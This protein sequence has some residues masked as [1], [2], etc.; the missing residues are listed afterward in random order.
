MAAVAAALAD[1][2]RSDHCI[3]AIFK[4]AWQHNYLSELNR[5]IQSIETQHG[6]GAV[7]INRN[8]A[9]ML[10]DEHII[11][12]QNSDGTVLLERAVSVKLN[13]ARYEAINSTLDQY[14]STD[15]CKLIS[16]YDDEIEIC[17]KNR[18]EIIA[19]ME[20]G[21][22][23]AKSALIAAASHQHQIRY[24]NELFKGKPL[25]LNSVDLSNLDLSGIDLTHANIC[26]ANLQNCCLVDASL[27]HASFTASNLNQANLMRANLT[28]TFLACTRLIAANLHAANLRGATLINTCLLCANLE[29]ADLGNSMDLDLT[30][31]NFANFKVGVYG[32]TRL[33]HQSLL[34][35]NK[36]QAH[37]DVIVV[38]D[39]S[40]AIPSSD[41][42]SM[43]RTL[44]IYEN[45]KRLLLANGLVIKDNR[46]GTME[47]SRGL[48]A[49]HDPLRS[50]AIGS[51]LLKTFP[52]VVTDLISSYDD[53]IEIS[54]RNEDAIVQILKSNDQS[55][56]GLLVGSACRQFKLVYLNQALGNLRQQGFQLN[57]SH[58]DLSNLNLTGLNLNNINLRHAVMHG[59]NL[60]QVTLH[61][62]NLTKA[63]LNGASL[64]KA[65]FTSAD[66]SGAS[67][68][69]AD[70][71]GA[72]LNQV[73][74]VGAVLKFAK[75]LDAE[76]QG[77]SNLT[78]AYLD[79]A[80]LELTNLTGA[81]MI[82]ASL[83][84]AKMFGTRLGRAN[85]TNAKL[86]HA[87]LS[88]AALHSVNL[89][90]ADLSGATIDNITLMDAPKLNGTIWTGVAATKIITDPATRKLLPLSIR[91]QCLD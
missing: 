67:L 57:F 70:L 35:L 52:K 42:S 19:I 8:V 29:Q 66:M 13:L 15:L 80:S 73:N 36:L 68:I 71:T 59:C 91:L 84:H 55:A 65:D 30:D 88:F 76:L 24:L 5:L 64:I 16:S 48:T 69:Q 90:H 61:H 51:T 56:K 74:L 50:Q 17:E 39:P 72:S 79:H 7:L 47:L 34:R 37:V 9:T 28:N 27:S 89:S 75:L 77:G 32:K 78:N 43:P 1:K 12:S 21:D 2:S 38:P 45:E 23:T 54:E 44:F 41:R 82:N 31:F 26:F 18:K 85:L 22:S 53:D 11:L 3:A 33:P 40:V 49:Q 63:N 87:Q 81:V 20:N 60:Y 10:A 83:T 62:A 25:N 58:V 46:N 6:A 4:N 86:M 14:L